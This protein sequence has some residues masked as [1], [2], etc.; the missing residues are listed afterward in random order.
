MLSLRE[1]NLKLLEQYYLLKHKDTFSLPVLVSSNGKYLEKI[2][3]APKRILYIGQ[4][5]NGWINDY[6]DASNISCAEIEEVYFDMLLKNGPSRRDFWTFIQ[7]ILQVETKEIGENIIWSNSLI[8]GKKYKVGPPEHAQELYDISVQNLLF[9]YQYFKPDLT[10]FCSGPNLPYYQ[11]NTDFLKRIN[12][13]LAE[14]YPQKNTPLLVDKQKQILWTYHPA[15]LHR[16][17]IKQQLEEEIHH[18]Y[19]KK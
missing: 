2:A 7:N 8:A 19:I 18:Q 6:N 16:Q 10:I 3:N 14:Q 11:V 1:E 9:L 4:E 5:T 15:Y 13:S 17:K 12:S